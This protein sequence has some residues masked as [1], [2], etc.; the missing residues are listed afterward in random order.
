[1][2]EFVRAG[3]VLLI[4][5]APLKAAAER[6]FVEAKGLNL[7]VVRHSSE[8][9]PPHN[10]DSA[11]A[12]EAIAA[13]VYRADIY[14]DVFGAPDPGADNA[15]VAGDRVDFDGTSVSARLQSFGLAMR[16]GIRR[17]VRRSRLRL[18]RNS[19]DRSHR[20]TV[21]TRIRTPRAA[22]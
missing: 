15:I 16:Y 17:A 11:L 20:C 3:F 14:E 19:A 18:H 2:S 22:V 9:R 1:M 7:V 6:G 21:L 4:D 13:K 10:L 8:S 5:A 12:A